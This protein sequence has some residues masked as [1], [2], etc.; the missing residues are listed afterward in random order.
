MGNRGSLFSVVRV[1]TSFNAV[2]YFFIQP[3]FFLDQ[4]A[5]QNLYSHESIRLLILGLGLP[6]N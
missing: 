5:R 4:V 2:V 6:W 1:N 3:Y